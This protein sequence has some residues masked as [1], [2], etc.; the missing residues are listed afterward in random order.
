MEVVTDK[1]LSKVEKDHVEFEDGSVIESAL[2]IIIPAY[3]G[4][5]AIVNSGLGDE[6]GFAPTNEQFQHLDYS[7]IY[8][9]G[10]GAA[11]TVPKLGHLAVEQGDI[12]AS[13]LKKFL[14]GRRSS[15]I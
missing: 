12:V 1:I 14:Q 10:D 4:P 9:I 5:D 15:P 11:R 2:T 13:H 6:A 7:N 8:A 3:Y